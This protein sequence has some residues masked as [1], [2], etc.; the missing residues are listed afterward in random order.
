MP[1][2]PTILQ[3]VA[4][5]YRERPDDVAKTVTDV[6]G[7]LARMSE[8]TH[9]TAQ[10]VDPAILARAI[11]G[12]S[13]L[14]DSTY[15]GFGS[16]PK[17]PSTASLALFLAYADQKNDATYLQRVTYTLGRMAWGGIYDQLGGGFHRY[18]TDA[19]WLTP[20]FEKMLYD[21]AQ[22]AP[23]YFATYQKTGDAFYLKIGEEILAY[24]LR[25]MTDAGGGFYTTQDADSEGV[26]GKFFVWTPDEM[27]TLLGEK[28]GA[29]LCRYY[30]VT[31]SGNFEGKN[32]LHLQKTLNVVSQELG[33]NLSEAEVALKEGREQLFLEREKRIKPFRDEKIITSLNGLMI[34]AFVA[35]YQVTRKAEYL[36][37]A[38]NA[39]R[40][41]MENLY[42]D[43]RLLRTM[44]DGVAKL[45]GYLDD[46]A[47]F[48]SALLDLYEATAKNE[49]L[50]TAR[51]LCAKL[52]GQF[53]DKQ[54]GGFFFTSHDHEKL[55]GRHKTYT[56]QSVPS[57]NAVAV[58][59]LLKL[60]AITKDDAYFMIA[61]KTLQSF[62]V[63]MEEN[64]FATGSLIAAAD[65]YIRTPKEITVTGKIGSL[66]MET[67]LAKIYRLYLPNKVVLITDVGAG[68]VPA[69]KLGT[70]EGC[71]Y[72]H[73]KPTVTL[74]QNQTCSLPMTEWEAIEKALLV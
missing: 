32:I 12:L 22:L 33:W 16:A 41:I 30:G 50:E 40:F 54:Q 55:V 14:F 67:L 2:F 29:L 60:Y 10:K 64:S 66:E 57:G 6:S 1:G 17:F 47:Y 11:S 36:I 23:L 9:L 69:Q 39:V 45:N 8:G 61:E 53:Y 34:S 15:G 3:E 72:N 38:E 13:P 4:A 63:A 59:A 37:A 21:N 44:K 35:G 46:Y 62:S 73:G 25:E 5:A 71:P 24:V 7:A 74:C 65:F 70:H 26:E 19:H 18:S 48:I 31:D 43:G 56:D 28:T 20:H 58:M 42:K 52:I 51:V 49:T 68:L 27:K